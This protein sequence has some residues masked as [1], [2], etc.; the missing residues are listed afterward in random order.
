MDSKKRL[1]IFGPF[2]SWRQPKHDFICAP[3]ILYWDTLAYAC[4]IY[5][6]NVLTQK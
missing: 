5:E 2:F 4:Q 3:E 1:N 6:G